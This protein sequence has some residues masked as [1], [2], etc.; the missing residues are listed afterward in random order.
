M[1]S[2]GG[3]AAGGADSDLMI[4]SF[5]RYS[6]LCLLLF[7]TAVAGS[8]V[9]EEQNELVKVCRP[10]LLRLNVL[11]LLDG[12]G[13]VSGRTFGLQMKML[14]KIANMMQIGKNESR[15]AVMQYAGYTRLEFGFE[16]HQDINAL[17]ESLRNIRHMSGTTKTGKAMLR[18][19][20]VFKKAKRNDE[21]GVSQVAVVVTDG[22]SHDDPIPAAEALRAAGVT[23]LTLGIGEHINRD[24]IVKISGKD[25]YAFQDL[26]K[27]I[28]LEHFVSGFKNLSQGEHCEYARGIDGAEI[29]CGPDFVV[30]EVSTTKKLKGRLFFEGFH[31]QPGCAST[32]A[33]VRAVPEKSRFDVH[34]KAPHQSCGLQ[35]VYEAKSRGFMIKSRAVL[36]FDGRFASTRDHTFEIRCTYPDKAKRPKIPHRALGVTTLLQDAID[37]GEEGP[38]SLERMKCSYHVTPRKE[39]CY[40][41]A[42]TVGTPLIH[43]WKCDEEHTRFQ[44][45]SCFIVDPVTHR[46]EEVI[47]SN[48]CHKEDSII[49]T[50]NY[51]KGGTVTATGKAI[52]FADVPLV[53]FS[54]R[55]RFCNS[56]NEQCSTSINRHCRSK[57][58]T[59]GENVTP[60]SSDTDDSEYD[61]SAYDELG[62]IQRDAQLATTTTIGGLILTHPPLFPS[63]G[64]DVILNTKTVAVVGSDQARD[65]FKQALQL[66]ANSL[67][68]G[69]PSATVG[70]LEELEMLREFSRDDLLKSEE[71]DMIVER[72]EGSADPPSQIRL[73]QGTSR[74]V[75]SLPVSSTSSSPP[76]PPPPPSD[77]PVASLAEAVDDDAEEEAVV[78]SDTLVIRIEHENFIT[79]CGQ[80]AQCL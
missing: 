16:D 22:H 77:P 65:R 8:Q 9:E 1:R 28:P 68:A 34:I 80:A 30:V 31:Q 38:S 55:I 63:G 4:V 51:S 5:I 71:M 33:D 78:I 17:M 79:G 25:E 14:N 15:I 61:N 52:R 24:E 27:E 50:L 10:I 12:S 44:V 35:R 19:L 73:P 60:R 42:I 20:D 46:T 59:I 69:K 56:S 13:S 48:G 49:G 21:H 29:T 58:E 54:C 74:F 45:H 64:V 75:L 39:H 66:R 57:R 7:V 47:D 41:N 36:Q 37:I 76:P 18:A 11:F 72:S 32:T 43:V 53:R 40:A 70:H 2:G 23:I 6:L 62:E 26:H 3:Y 67:A